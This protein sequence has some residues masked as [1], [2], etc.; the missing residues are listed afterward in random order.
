MVAEQEKRAPIDKIIGFGNRVNL[1]VKV[2]VFVISH[3][4]LSDKGA[5]E[6]RASLGRFR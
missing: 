2:V 5:F 1:K 3:N 6:L 4:A